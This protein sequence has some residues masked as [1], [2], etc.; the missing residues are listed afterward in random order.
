[1]KC[2]SPETI[3]G[4]INS[5]AQQTNMLSLNASI[6]AAR[7]GEMGKGFAVVAAQVGELAARS[8]QAAQE[9][10]ELIT[11]SIK[12]VEEGKEITDRTAN[13]FGMAVENIKKANK[14][15][16]EITKMVSQNMNI[17]TNA[18]SQIVQISD[19][20][21]QNVQISH[22]TKQVSSNMADITGKLLNIVEN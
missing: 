21:E 8:S 13:A 14:D 20:V 3:I 19:V 1:M 4:D 16:R 10:N 17:V 12:A 6:E 22:E 11:N 18:V 15:V 7:A 5:I 9:T 2:P